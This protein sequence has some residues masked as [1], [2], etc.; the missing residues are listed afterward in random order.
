M[1]FR[2]IKNKKNISTPTKI[3][4]YYQCSI[5]QIKWV[6]SIR[7]FSRI[8]L[9]KGELLYKIWSQI[10]LYYLFVFLYKLVRERQIE[11]TMQFNTK[12]SFSSRRIS[13]IFGSTFRDEPSLTNLLHNSEYR[14]F[15]CIFFCLDLRHRKKI[16][17]I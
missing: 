3:F 10:I 11:N 12:F 15:N 8:L 2:L 9:A 6:E 16:N 1:Y 4:Y 5:K 17:L 14:L 7:F 13:G